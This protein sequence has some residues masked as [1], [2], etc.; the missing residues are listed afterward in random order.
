M[1]PESEP[2][3]EKH[4]SKWHTLNGDSVKCRAIWRFLFVL[5]LIYVAILFLLKF[6]FF[7]F[8]SNNLSYPICL[9]ARFM[10][11]LVDFEFLWFCCKAS[12]SQVWRLWRSLWRFLCH[13]KSC[14]KLSNDWKIQSSSQ[15]E[16]DLKIFRTKSSNC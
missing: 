3:V 11:T 7:S 16:E 4:W 12:S 6:I 14:R 15:S 2:L 8:S 1:R 10:A 9:R 13:W 5:S